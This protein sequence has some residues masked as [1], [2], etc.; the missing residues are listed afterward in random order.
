M[1]ISG[2]RINFIT[3]YLHTQRSLQNISK[4]LDDLNECELSID[5]IKQ[6]RTENRNLC[7]ASN[8]V[9][10]AMIEIFGSKRVLTE[11]D[12]VSLK[13]DINFDNLLIG[14]D[15][16]EIMLTN[17]DTGPKFLNLCCTYV[18]TVVSIDKRIR[19]EII[20]LE[21]RLE[22]KPPF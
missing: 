3:A 15:L 22:D 8:E 10:R 9:I 12:S 7:L 6:I 21:K 1:E 19:A 14:P 11:Y 20:N 18:S 4:H 16:I 13:Q 2:E 17:N 5:E